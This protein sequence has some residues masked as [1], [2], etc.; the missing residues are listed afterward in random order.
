MFAMEMKYLYK[1]QRFPLT[2]P[3]LQMVHNR[4]HVQDMDFLLLI[5]GER[6][7]G[8]STVAVRLCELVDPDFTIQNVVFSPKEF[9]DLLRSGKLK[10][11][12]A[13]LLDEA[14]V[15][16][17]SRDW[18]SSQSKSFNSFTQVSRTMHLFVVFT[19]PS[20]K[21]VDSQVLKNLAAVCTIASKLVTKQLT[22][23]RILR[24]Q[25][26]PL[27]DVVYHKYYR[28][29]DRKSGRI[30]RLSRIGFHLPSPGLLKAYKAKRKAF[31][32]VVLGDLD[33]TIKTKKY[34]KY[35]EE[36]KVAK[37]VK[38]VIDLEKVY[39]SVVQSRAKYQTGARGAYDDQLIKKDFNIT[40]QQAEK[41]AKK[42]HAAEIHIME[43]VP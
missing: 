40:A 43:G 42:A 38:I 18:F 39:A 6:G 10:D 41:I 4:L 19:A 23:V 3:F 37:P 9:T 12:S 11:G 20:E 5:V 13:V 25:P 27:S 34:T 24:S 16:F 26:A 32:D 30:R 2:H 31:V 35:G 8:K 33:T 36:T 21:M 17:G 28:F 7:S 15:A 29:I 22:W 1:R 14:G